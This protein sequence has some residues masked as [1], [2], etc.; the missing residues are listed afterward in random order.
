MVQPRTVPR[1]IPLV[2]IVHSDFPLWLVIH[3]FMS[4][5][6]GVQLGMR[7]HGD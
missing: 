2:Q 1:L 7:G 6:Q 5:Y 3:I 4:L